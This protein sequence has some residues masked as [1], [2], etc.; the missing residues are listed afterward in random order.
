MVLLLGLALW[1]GGWLPGPAQSIAQA[2]PAAVASVATD[3][4]TTYEQDPFDRTQVRR[5]TVRV[6]E[7][8]IVYSDGRTELRDLRK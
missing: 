8:A 4:V 5:S 2:P 6:T 3:W 1:A 7:V